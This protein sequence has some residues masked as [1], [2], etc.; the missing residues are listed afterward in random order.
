ME[1]QQIVELLLSL[2]A[3]TDTNQEKA[4]AD[5]KADQ[6]KAD[7]NRQ[8]DREL[9]IGIMDENAKSM[10]EDVKSG[11]AEMTSTIRAFHEKMDAWIANRKNDREET[12]ACHDEMEV[13]IKKM[14]PNPGEKK[15]VVERQEF[16]NNEV[17]VHSQR[18][19]QSKRAVSQGG[20]ETEPD[21]RKLQSVE[22]HQEI[23][24]EKAVV[25]PV[26]GRKKRHRGRKPAA[27]R[28]GEPDKL[29]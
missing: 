6:E 28:R 16:S 2:Q 24:K 21:P 3:K 19:C 27:G 29:T 18:T 15:A 12:I 5:R 4:D 8:A 23:P 17:A 25:K 11:Q 7:A 13:R 10:R 1:S 9:L 20:T 26:K 22:E 14:E